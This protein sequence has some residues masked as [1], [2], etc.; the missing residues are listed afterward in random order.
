MDG[1]GCPDGSDEVVGVDGPV[2]GGGD[3]VVGF[4]EVF[5]YFGAYLAWCAV[6]LAEVEDVEPC[7]VYVAFDDVV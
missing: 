1:E 4:A 6:G 2:V 5:G 3:V 7:G